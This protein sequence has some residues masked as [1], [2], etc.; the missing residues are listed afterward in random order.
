MEKRR[1]RKKREVLLCCSVVDKVGEK[2]ANG[3]HE[4]E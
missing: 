1:N 3:D 4:L 2:D